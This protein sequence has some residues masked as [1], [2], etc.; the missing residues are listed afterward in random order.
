MNTVLTKDGDPDGT[1]R[2]KILIY[3]ADHN[4]MTVAT[5]EPWAAAVF[6]VNDGCTLYFLSSPRS[7][8]C[9]NL[10]ADPRV[11]ITIQEDYADW[12]AIKG[13][14]LEGVVAPVAAD[15]EA[16]VRALYGAKF[17]VI[18]QAQGAASAIAQALARIRW[19]Q[20][21]PRRIHFI[22]NAAG[23]GQRDTLELANKA[24]E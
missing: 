18:H 9:A 4:V 14:Q 5:A 16:R 24:E 13:I 17:P 23:F 10:T 7:R 3:L 21:T 6:Y 20:V 15:D 8:H 1:L 22:D 2:A 12:R 11:A 19:Y